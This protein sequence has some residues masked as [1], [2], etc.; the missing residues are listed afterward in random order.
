MFFFFS[1]TLS[2]LIRP[3]VIICACLVLSW[4]L[5]NP[6]WK[7]R[8]FIFA[9]SLLLFLSNDFIA[10]EFMM[11]WEVRAT[12]F[13]EISRQYEYGIVLSGASRSE[14]G[15]TDRV[16]ISS[17]A[18]RINHTLQLYKSGYI[19]KILVSGGSGRLIDIGEREAEQL[20]SL[21]VMMGVPPGD[22]MIENDSRNTHESAEVVA[23]MLAGKTTSAQCLLITSANHMPRA[24]ACFA[25]AGWPMDTFSTDFF[26]HYRKFTFDVLFIPKIE[27][28]TTWNILIREWVGYVSYWLAGYV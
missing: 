10:N 25:K 18:D 22:I 27:A 9:T 13:S 5:K 23:K 19:K 24:A 7:K 14:V 2:Y 3:L 4:F 11:M 15:P 26:S 17:A 12:P 20:A 8:L 1:K 28:F 21:F 6:H 16:Y